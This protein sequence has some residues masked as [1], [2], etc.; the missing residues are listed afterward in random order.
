MKKILSHL[1]ELGLSEYEGKAYLCLLRNN[2]AT[3]YEVGRR[4]GIPTSKIYEVV[5]KLL[6]KGIITVVETEKKKRY[7]PVEP[8][9]FLE[10]YKS[11]TEAVAGALK[12]SLSLL[13]DTMDF[14]SVWNIS[15]YGYL[16]DKVKQAI[17]GAKRA[18]LLS[19][20]KEELDQMEDAVRDAAARNVNVAIVHFGSTRFKWAQLYLHPI[21]D[22][23]YEEKGGRGIVVVV[24]SK[25]VLMG[26]IFKYGRV[27][28]TWS[29]NPG[30]ITMAEDYIKHDVYVM[31]IIKRFDNLLKSRFGG[32]YEKLRDVFS[33]EEIH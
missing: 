26:T 14:S 3:A 12:R 10:R 22:T 19:V 20:W 21:E 33:D 24:D 15:D 5:S 31:K 28:G 30:F 29:R 13:D 6:D 9:V 25:E 8:D 18:V 23:L 32:R 1:S 2:P 16:M 4:A 27:S 7:L 17:H 11:R